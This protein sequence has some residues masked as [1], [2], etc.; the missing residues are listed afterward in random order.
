MLRWLH[1]GDNEFPST[2]SALDEP[3]GLLAASDTIDINR[4]ISAYRRGIFPWYSD[5]QPVLW[6]SPD[7]RM[8]ITPSSLHISKSMKK[9][10]NK[11]HFNVTTDQC[12]QEVV[13]CCAETRADQEGT[14]ITDEI[15]T[16][17][18]LMH[19]L[20]YAHSVEVWESDK[21]V[22]GLYGIAMGRVF[23]G[24][25]MFSLSSNAS[26]YALITIARHLFEQLNFGLID[27]QV[28]SD[29][30]ESLGGIDISRAEFERALLEFETSQP[31]EWPDA[32]STL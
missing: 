12:F 15:E 31:A 30:M 19:Q 5:D 3:N 25:S 10:L 29:H 28:A 14:W 9:L 21:L 16:H 11:R 13:Q 18:C 7:P 22:G 6:W 8:V 4:L 26:K 32:E 23:F 1:E 20:G 24:E 27:C 2:S 17:Y